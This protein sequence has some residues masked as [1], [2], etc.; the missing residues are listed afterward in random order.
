VLECTGR[1]PLSSG[2]EKRPRRTSLEEIAH[3]C[4]ETLQRVHKSRNLSR[5][6]KGLSLGGKVP[7]HIEP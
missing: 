3:L 4:A 1:T 5:F 6:Q 7:L 2:I